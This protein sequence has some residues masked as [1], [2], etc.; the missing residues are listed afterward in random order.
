MF[1]NYFF[2]KNQNDINTLL[3]DRGMKH[4]VA[5]T[6]LLIVLFFCSQIVGL[7]VLQAY[8]GINE[9]TGEEEWKELP[10]VGE[11]QLE[12]PDLSPSES[13]WYMISAIIIGTVLVLFLIKYRKM[14]LWKTWFYLAVIICLTISLGVFIGGLSAFLLSLVL[15]YFKIFRPNMII[16]NLTELFLYA[17]MAALF[18]PLLNMVFMSLLLIIIS[19]YDYYAVHK[20]KHMITMATF[21]SNAKIFAGLLIPYGKTKQGEGKRTKRRATEKKEKQQRAAIL[22]GGD[23]AFPLFFAGVMLKTYGIPES[24]LIAVTTTLALSWLLFKGEQ[25]KFYPAMPT[26]SIGCFLG[27]G[28]AFLFW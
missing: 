10:A 8:L 12:R 25:G 9:E 16:H 18:V 13:F 5:I 24:I 19:L 17:G 6:L 23:I 20:S 28:I 7:W 4:S 22:G 14:Y 26:L 3:S 1:F 2:L 15:G 11:V 27:W 21:Q